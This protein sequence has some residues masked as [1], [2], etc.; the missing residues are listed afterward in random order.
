MHG[1]NLPIV[2]LM[3]QYDI[4]EQIAQDLQSSVY[5]MIY[6]SSK[7]QNSPSFNALSVLEIQN[8]FWTVFAHVHANC[9]SQGCTIVPAQTLNEAQERYDYMQSIIGDWD[10]DIQARELKKYHNNFKN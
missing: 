2:E 3:I 6:L 10:A 1:I 5:S 7:A 8:T 9:P 4:S